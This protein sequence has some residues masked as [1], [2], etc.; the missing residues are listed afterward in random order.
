M[1]VVRQRA[2]GNWQ[3]RFS[4]GG[5]RIERSILARTKTE[6]QRIADELERREDRVRLGLEDA[7]SLVSIGQAF[8]RYYPTTR[9]LRS[10]ETIGLRFRKWIL[11]KLKDVMLHRLTPADV[12]RFLGWCMDQGLKPQSVKHIRNHLSALYTFAIDRERVFRGPNPVRQSQLIDIPDRKPKYIDGESVQR[13][14]DNA[15]DYYRGIIATGFYT[16]LRRSELWGLRPEDV[17]LRRGF[18][19]VLSPKTGKYREV[20][21]HTQLVPYLLQALEGAR[22]EWLF[23]ARDGSQLNASSQ[24]NDRLAIA[25]RRAGLIQGFNVSCRRKGCKFRERRAT[26]GEGACPRCGFKLTVTAVPVKF[27]FKDMRSTLATL[28]YEATGDIRVV[29]RTL[30]HSDPRLTERTYAGNRAEHMVAQHNRLSFGVPVLT[31]GQTERTQAEPKEA[32][33]S[34]PERERNQGEPT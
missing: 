8:E 33:Q 26:A 15:P 3:V 22:S 27:T 34:Q 23:P 4:V 31:Q 12:D 6:A 21:I 32:K 7:P 30:G 28:L 13:V 11:P 29:Q 17:D 9:A 19:Q 20:V 1:A 10:H 18:L 14:I 25:V 16:G 24:L 2:P 5:R